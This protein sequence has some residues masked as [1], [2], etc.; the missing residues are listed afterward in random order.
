MKEGTMKKQ[1]SVLCLML[2][3]GALLTSASPGYCYREKPDD[4][5]SDNSCT[6]GVKKILITY[7]TE[8]GSTALV[9]KQ[10]FD[11]LCAADYSVDLIFVEYFDPAEILNYDGIV[12]GSPIYIGKWL[13]G[14]N[15]LLKRH[16]ATIAQ[17]P[18]AFFITCTNVRDLTTDNESAAKYQ[19][20]LTVFMNPVLDKYTDLN[21]VSKK[22]LA[23]GFWFDELYPFQRFLMKLAKYPEG[24]FRKPNLIDAWA[25]DLADKFK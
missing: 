2:A 25:E 16:H 12:I 15:K 9:A 20:S 5:V 6:H 10:I 13:P 4:L 18:S 21:I 17:I 7:D 22:V 23:G 1:F 3:L 19:E 8:H 11:D 14:I 24:D